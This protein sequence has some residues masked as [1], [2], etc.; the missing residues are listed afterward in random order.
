MERL[1]TRGVEEVI[2]KEH[3]AFRLAQGEKL[4]VKFGIDPTN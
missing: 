2:I 1:L 3:L 4:R